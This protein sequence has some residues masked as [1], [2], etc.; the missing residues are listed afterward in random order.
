MNANGRK[1]GMPLH[2]LHY[3]EKLAVAVRL[4]AVD[5]SDQT[6]VPITV[7]LDAIDA[8]VHLMSTNCSKPSSSEVNGVFFA[9]ADYIFGAFAKNLDLPIVINRHSVQALSRLLRAQINHGN[10]GRSGTATRPT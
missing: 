10:I 4:W 7:K 2:P 6:V 8:V 1:F 5:P 9:M 3:R